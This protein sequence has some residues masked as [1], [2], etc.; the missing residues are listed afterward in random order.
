MEEMLKT[1][2]TSWLADITQWASAQA[3][4]YCQNSR[5][6]VL[7]MSWMKETAKRTKTKLPNSS[8]AFVFWVFCGSSGSTPHPWTLNS[9]SPWA[10]VLDKQ[11]TIMNLTGKKG[12][13]NT[14][15]WLHNGG[16]TCNAVLLISSQHLATDLVFQQ[17]PAS[18]RQQALFWCGSQ[19]QAAITK[20]LHMQK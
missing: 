9:F 19:F 1:C 3:I 7:S 2:C 5:H 13:L 14:W 10:V 12:S 17:L 15:G 11:G 16:I 18:A 20:D 4:C 8:D 6:M